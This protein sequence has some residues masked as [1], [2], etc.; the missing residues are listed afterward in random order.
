MRKQ[1]ILSRP[2]W[3]LPAKAK[4]ETLR[5][6]LVTFAALTMAGCA[7]N[8][9]AEVLI[10]PLKQRLI[11]REDIA[12]QNLLFA[13]TPAYASGSSISYL[14]APYDGPA[15]EPPLPDLSLLPEDLPPWEEQLE[16]LPLVPDGIPDPMTAPAPAPIP[17]P[18]AAPTPQ[19]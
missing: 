10:D 18:E 3:P 4:I 17:S 7:S 13:R 1:S 15:I 16:T 19:T 2:T 11:A 8:P 9:N 12:L 14:D 5:V 6:G